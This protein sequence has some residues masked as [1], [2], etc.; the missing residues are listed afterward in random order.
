VVVVCADSVPC[1]RGTS[2]L[3]TAAGVQ[4]TPDSLEDRVRAVLAKV[5][6]GEADA[7]IVYVTDALAAASTIDAVTIPAEVNST[8]EYPIAIT[9]NSRNPIT[10]RAFVDFVAGP[11]ARAILEKYGFA[12][13]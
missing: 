4:L 8:T 11:T 2:A 9:R 6:A 1:G 10:A 13:P 7:G 12:A 5:A 3:L